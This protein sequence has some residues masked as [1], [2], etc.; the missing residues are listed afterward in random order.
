MCPESDDDF[1]E[2]VKMDRAQNPRVHQDTCLMKDQ[3]NTSTRTL[4]ESKLDYNVDEFRVRY[5]VENHKR[6]ALER[7]VITGSNSK[8]GS[9]SLVFVNKSTPFLKIKIRLINSPVKT[10]IYFSQFH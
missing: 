8:F 2:N 10:L 6:N 4:S 5:P 7:N 3:I 1:D 9:H